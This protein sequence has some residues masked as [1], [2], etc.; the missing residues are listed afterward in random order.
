M[1]YIQPKLKGRRPRTNCFDSRRHGSKE[2]IAPKGPG[3]LSNWTPKVCVVGRPLL[4]QIRGTALAFRSATEI[5]TS[6]V[7]RFRSDIGAMVRRQRYQAQ[8]RPG[9]KIC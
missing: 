1:A 4:T 9:I 6:P 5:E 2:S 7:G 3:L 8:S